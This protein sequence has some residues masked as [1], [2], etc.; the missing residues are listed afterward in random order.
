MTRETKIGLLVGLAFIIIVGILL[1]EPM[2]H[3]NE[4]PQAPLVN[5]TH[6]VRSGS[7]QPSS[8]SPPV[9]TPA[10]IVTLEH[11]VPT[12]SEARR[13]QGISVVNI[14]AADQPGQP[15]RLTIDGGSGRVPAAPTYDRERVLPAA[16]P[17]DDSQPGDA[18]PGPDAIARR[19]APSD[20]HGH[21]PESMGDQLVPSDLHGQPLPEGM[22]RREVADRTDAPVKPATAMKAYEA[23]AGDT[24]SKMAG[25]FM[26]SNSK[27]NRQAIIDANPSLKDAPDKV[28]AGHEYNIPLPAAV[29]TSSQLGA[30]AP[31]PADQTPADHSTPVARGIAPPGSRVV[32]APVP[33]SA[34][35]A[36]ARTTEHFYVVQPGDNLTRIAVQKLGDARAVAAIKELNKELLKGGD[37]VMPNM[38]L[39]LPAAPI[40]SAN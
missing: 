5:V 13:P 19:G 9:V 15:R 31:R 2:S 17:V 18:G 21:G 3:A 6:D 35:E 27:A 29:A 34:S 7:A 12:V 11:P 39:R 10:P 30:P 25:R 38:K 16:R 40:A 23:V 1:T 26:G 22:A 14:G 28:I 33:S 24:L 4:L 36:L 32:P 8:S 20:A 37:M